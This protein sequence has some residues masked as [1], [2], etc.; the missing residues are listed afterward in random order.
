MG[1]GSASGLP[2]DP[3]VE[4]GT[5]QAAEDGDGYEGGCG[6][7]VPRPEAVSRGKGLALCPLGGQSCKWS[8]G[9]YLRSRHTDTE[10]R[11]SEM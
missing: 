10:M 7:C 8:E 2:R 4:G 11:R 6:P 1:R 9:F 3:G 5:L